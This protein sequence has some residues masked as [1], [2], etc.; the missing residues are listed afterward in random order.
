[1]RLRLAAVALMYLIVCPLLAED[2][3]VKTADFPKVDKL[4]VVAELPDPFL[5]PDGS[6]VMTKDEWNSQ[7][8][9]LLAALRVWFAAARSQKRGGDGASQQEDR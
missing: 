7:R 2:T 1:M 6:R 9:D 8:K 5:R 3:K 4:P